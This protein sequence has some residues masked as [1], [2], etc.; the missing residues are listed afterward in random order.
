MWT[1]QAVEQ[2]KAGNGQ[3]V[4]G[5]SPIGKEKAYGGKDLPKSQV[6]SSG[7]RWFSAL[8]R[9]YD[10]DIVCALISRKRK[11]PGSWFL[12]PVERALVSFR[13]VQQTPRSCPGGGAGRPKG[14]PKT[15][16]FQN[17]LHNHLSKVWWRSVKGFRGGVGQILPL[18][19]NWLWSSSLYYTLSLPFECAMSKRHR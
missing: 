18:P 8:F 2:S 14:G 3:V 10:Y 11:E 15:P 4:R 5:V 7:V 17:L 6:L 13:I 1:N 16:K 19:V 9:H 12:A